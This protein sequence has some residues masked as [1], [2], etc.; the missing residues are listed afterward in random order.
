MAQLP[1][2]AFVCASTQTA[3]IFRGN[4]EIFGAV[5]ELGGDSSW[6]QCIDPSD[7]SVSYRDGHVVT[8]WRVPG[9]IVEMGVNRLWVFPRR[10]RGLREDRIVLADPTLLGLARPPLD[11][12]EILIVHD[13]RP[14]SAY[15]DRTRMRWI[16]RHLFPRMRRVRRIVVR[17]E[18]LKSR[19]EANPDARGKICVVPPTDFGPFVG[20]EDHIQR[21]LARIAE[22]GELRVLSVSTDRPYKNL[23]RVFELAR[24]FDGQSN[25]KI[26]FV[27]VCR[28]QDSTVR[29]LRGNPIR[30]LTV[31]PQV[32][33]IRTVFDDAD[34]LLFP[35]LYEGLGHPLVDA[36]SCGMPI[37][38]SDL[39]PMREVVGV[40]GHLLDPARDDAWIEALRSLGDPSTYAAQAKRAWVRSLDFSHDRFLARIP[41]MLA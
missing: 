13:L 11:G 1:S 26:R 16:F 29:E 4:F 7:P 37:L 2:S 6:Y 3:G 30:N 34:A 31:I 19:L 41:P 23:R 17:T 20:G 25:P 15:N 18:H 9:G 12:R 35:S 8:G 10:L 21:S 27:L 14:F 28:L 5:R 38:A 33:D 22:S 32:P 39:E 40:G 24:R 36:M